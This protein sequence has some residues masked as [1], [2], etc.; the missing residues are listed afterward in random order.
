MG[1]GIGASAERGSPGLGTATPEGNSENEKVP[2]QEREEVPSSG[3]Q[4]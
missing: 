2:Q 1:A 3:H 4:A